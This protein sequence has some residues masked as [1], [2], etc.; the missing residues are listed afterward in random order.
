MLK[1]EKNWIC[2]AKG[3][4]AEWLWVSEGCKHQ[5]REEVVA[6]A[7]EGKSGAKDML[8][9]IRQNS[10]GT[11][12]EWPSG[13][14]VKPSVW[15]ILGQWHSWAFGII[16]L[17]FGVHLFESL[18]KKASL[19]WRKE[20]ENKTSFPWFKKTANLLLWESCG[21]KMPQVNPIPTV[22]VEASIIPFL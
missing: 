7:Y 17:T 6:G 11:V 10:R 12:R 1:D 13:K 9:S 20:K 19:L 16:F 14:S 21:W 8:V 3:R 5:G 15:Y 22:L 18:T 4:H 2:I